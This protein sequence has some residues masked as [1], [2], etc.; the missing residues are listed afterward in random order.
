MRLEALR[1]DSKGWSMASFPNLDSASTLVVVFGSTEFLDRPQAID[2]LGQAYPRAHFIG[3]SS[4]G[5]IFGNKIYDGTLS[6]AVAKFEHS[7]LKTGSAVVR[8]AEDSLSAGQA[9]AQQLSQP[10]LRA[11]FV[12]S[13][14]LHVN[15][16]EL[17]KGLNSG[18][19]AGVVVTGG[20]AGD[21]DRF[22]RTWVINSARR[23]ESCIVSAVGF[24]GDRIAIGH[25]SK[26]GWDNFGP[27]RMVTR[28]QSNV[29][30]ELD[31]TPALKL[32]RDYLGE[33]ASGLPATALLFP[34]AIR[35]SESEEKRLVRTI[36]AINEEQQSM[37]FAGDVPTGW[38]AQL[39]RANF[40]RLIEGASDAAQSARARGRNS[41]TTLALAISCV[42]RRLVLGERTEEEVEAT[43]DALPKHTKQVGFYSYGE[44]S[45]FATGAGDLH[46][47]T[48]TL[49]TISETEV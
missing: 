22:S 27:E 20:L 41:E 35:K 16:S 43:L 11:V 23:P 19:A 10:G 12:L 47:Q 15:G 42:G 39:M 8:R 9:L 31:G 14:G 32:Y 29:L 7:Q 5:E 26:G 38:R 40:D 33:R 37:T 48:M 3:C 46:N 44:I 18:L 4:A 36:L 2:A 1:Y 17:V 24:Y 49:T 30:F 25:G 34:L 21:R 28:A 6:V 13:D 45:P